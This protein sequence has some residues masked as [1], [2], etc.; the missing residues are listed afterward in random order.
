M[1]GESQ[2]PRPKRRAA[3]LGNGVEKR[4]IS[5]AAMATAAGVGA[6]AGPPAAE[7][8][9]VYTDTWIAIGPTGGP[10]KI[11]L[12]NDG[13]PDFSIVVAARSYSSSNDFVQ[14]GTL[15]ASPLGSN[16]VCGTKGNASAFQ[17]GIKVGSSAKFGVGKLLMGKE[18]DF[19][20]DCGGSYVTDY[21]STGNW[22]Q[23]TRLF[24][25][26]KFTIQGQVHYGWARFNVSATFKGMYAALIG[27]AYESDPNVPI[28]TGQ[29]SGE[30]KG[31]GKK[32]GATF[33]QPGELGALAAGTRAW[34]A[35]GQAQGDGR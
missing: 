32:V 27:Y 9:V 4:L 33:M 31:K 24:L 8:K 23:A 6:L 1:S 3:A 7:A 34:G 21:G 18:F 19:F 16:A 30:S 2:K 11:D 28:V 10:Y 17:P 26:F 22:K 29:T 25:G 35:T 5:Y 12:N 15:T 14:K 13:V 20:E